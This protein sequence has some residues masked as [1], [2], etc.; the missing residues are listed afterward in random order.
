MSKAEAQISAKLRQSFENDLQSMAVSIRT[1]IFKYNLFVN[2]IECICNEYIYVY[3][4]FVASNC[5]VPW[6][7]SNGNDVSYRYNLSK[8]RWSD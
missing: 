2:N 4:Y 3:I 6:P 7:S 8:P 1:H 5:Y